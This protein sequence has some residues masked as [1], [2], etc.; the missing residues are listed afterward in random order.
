M[1]KAT[2][3]QFYS[4]MKHGIYNFTKNGKCSSCGNCCT[5]LLPMKKEELKAIKRYVKRKH[6][7]AVK[8]EAVDLDLSCPFRDDEKRICMIYE[9]RPFICKTFVCNKPQNKIEW[10]RDRLSFDSSFSV[11]YLRE[12]F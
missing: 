10:E 11:L 9:V 8:H 3:D 6:I 1:K 7:K 5:A 12:H 4:D 2:L